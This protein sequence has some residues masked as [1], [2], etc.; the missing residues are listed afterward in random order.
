MSVQ[1]I[2]SWQINS[3]NQER[4]EVHRSIDGGPAETIA[5]LAADVTTYTDTQDVV[6]TDRI[7]Y[8]VSSVATIKG[9]EVRQTSREIS[10][11]VGVMTT[12]YTYTTA[13]ENFT[14]TSLSPFKLIFDGVEHT[15]LVT[16]TNFQLSVSTTA[17]TAIE[18]YPASMD[19]GYESEIVISGGASE[20]ISWSDFDFGNSPVMIKPNYQPLTKVPE[21]AP[22]TTSLLRL[23]SG[24]EILNDPNISLWDTTNVVNMNRTFQNA[25]IFNQQ[26]LGWVTTSVTDMEMAFHAALAFNQNLTVW[27]TPH[28]DKEPIDF[29][30]LSKLTPNRLPV[31]GTVVEKTEDAFVVNY[32]GVRTITITA[33][34]AIGPL[35]IEWAAGNVETVIPTGS[36][37]TKSLPSTTTSTLKVKG[38][39]TGRLGL[40]VTVNSVISDGITAVT[41]FGNTGAN[42][43]SLKGSGQLLN[44]PSSLPL[45][46]T[47]CFEMFH[48]CQKM[49]DPNVSNWNMSRV[50]NIS[51]MFCQARAFN[52]ILNWDV[53]QVTTTQSLFELCDKFNQPM[54]QL[55]FENLTNTASMFENAIVFNQELNDM[56]V[57]KVTNMS[58]M[59]YA[60]KKFN[61]PL[62]KWKV[63]NVTLMPSFLRSAS[64]FNQDLSM[65]CVGKIPSLPT[66]FN[67]SGI[68]TPAY[69][70]VWGTC[71]AG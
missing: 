39:I 54:V 18:V 48:T 12:P 42:H 41:S 61:R 11:K 63:D 52:Q 19:V 35:E 58:K 64:V 27:S 33:E 69:F 5:T 28:F 20:V 60:A 23:F 62:N 30:H 21:T 8:T 70:P 31:W 67:R 59:L 53:R 47:S 36:T 51:F 16:E 44:V 71:P 66:D 43:I 13:S 50:T 22:N 65:W 40:A 34:G 4:Q 68:L 26:L 25:T 3:I 32:K 29:T 38:N 6:Y 10:T 57:S 24:A 56:D 17:G 15:A 9:V 2:L 55:S 46:V 49:N 37:I 7:N 14:V 45:T 1:R